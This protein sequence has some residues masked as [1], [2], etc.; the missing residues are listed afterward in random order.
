M[1]EYGCIHARDSE[2]AGEGHQAEGGRVELNRIRDKGHIRQHDDGEV[3]GVGLVPEIDLWCL[4]DELEQGLAPENHAKPVVRYY[5]HL[6]VCARAC[7]S[8]YGSEGE[9]MAV[10]HGG[11]ER[12]CACTCA[13]RILT[14]HT[15]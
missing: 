14:W 11:R 7:V 10:R 9:Q 1:Y 3:E 15:P 5:V 4:S 8:A 6:P 2:Q 12:S 13:P